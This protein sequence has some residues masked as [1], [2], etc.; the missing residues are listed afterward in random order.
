[1]DKISEI[2]RVYFEKK[3]KIR[4]FIFTFSMYHESIRNFAHDHKTRYTCPQ[5]AQLKPKI[6]TYVKY[7]TSI[8][9]D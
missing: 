9:Q 5:S 8:F 3:H 1:M 4:E 2:G 7:Q 6:G